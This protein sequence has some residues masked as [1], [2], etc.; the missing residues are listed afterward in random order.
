MRDALLV[1]RLKPGQK[2]TN[3]QLAV[4]MDVSVTPVREALQRLVAE[5]VLNL[6]PNGSV[7]VPVYSEEE[8]IE[9]YRVTKALEGLAARLAFQN[10]DGEFIDRIMIQSQGLRSAY[11]SEDWP[12]VFSANYKLH[13]ALYELANSPY[14]YTLIER[15]WMRKGP[16]YTSFF[17][18]HY[19]KYQ[20]GL[21]SNIVN[22]FQSG[23][24]DKAL[25]E[26]D[27]L[28]DREFEAWI[29]IVQSHDLPNIADAPI[30]G[31]TFTPE[32]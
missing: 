10:A 21:L 5:H 8:V 31:T 30:D 24:M 14:L 28:I 20:G 7:V 22:A 9:L 19:T 4:A 27:G 26:F 15:L 25:A 2:M 32:W 29:A 18:S 12:S 11:A 13:F 16:H 1:G 3:R 17:E 6:L 23:D